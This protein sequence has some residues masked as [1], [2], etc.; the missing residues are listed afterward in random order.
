MAAYQ[1][2]LNSKFLSNIKAVFENARAYI[3]VFPH[4]QENGQGTQT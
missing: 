4:N 3:L 1:Q 2:T